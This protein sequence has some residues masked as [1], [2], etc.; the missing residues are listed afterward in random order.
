MIHFPKVQEL[1][2]HHQH[3]L[4]DPLGQGPEKMQEIEIETHRITSAFDSMQ[5]SIRRMDMSVT[6]RKTLYSVIF[7]C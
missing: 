4:R 2:E 7:V 6:E 1:R 5:K 3:Y